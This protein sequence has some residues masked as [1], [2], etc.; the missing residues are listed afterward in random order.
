MNILVPNILY[1]VDLAVTENSV[2]YLELNSFVSA[3][4]YDMNY[5]KIVKY[6]ESIK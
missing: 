2:K 4:L 5:D 3:G 6:I 1:T